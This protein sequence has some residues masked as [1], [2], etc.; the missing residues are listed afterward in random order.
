MLGIV[1]VDSKGDGVVDLKE[2]TTALSKWMALV[3]YPGSRDLIHPFA[4]AR[5]IA[6]DFCIAMKLDPRKQ[7]S[8]I[9]ASHQVLCLLGY[10][11]L[12]I[13][14]CMLHPPLMGVPACCT[15]NVFEPC[16]CSAMTSCKDC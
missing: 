9:S 8:P 15:Y 11:G 3:A 1:Q 6:L 12:Y 10:A 5:D 2:L 13:A 16:S 4:S 14:T 7:V